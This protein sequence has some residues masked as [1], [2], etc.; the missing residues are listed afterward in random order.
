M[1]GDFP[2]L[3]IQDGRL[4]ETQAAYITDAIRGIIRAINGK[5][6]FGSGVHSSQ[7]G[8]IDGHTKEHTFVLA[9]TDY[10]IPHG[11]GRVPIGIITLDVNQD[12]AVVRGNDR[13]SWGLDRLILRC[14]VADTTALFIVV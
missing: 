14:S 1:L 13:G 7:S 5:I 11:L 6:T 9:N 10:E 8:N 2:P 3:A 12:G 4:T